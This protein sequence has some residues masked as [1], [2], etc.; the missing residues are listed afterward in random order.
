MEVNGDRGNHLPG[1]GRRERAGGRCGMDRG[2]LGARDWRAPMEYLG[3]QACLDG[4]QDEREGRDTRG[5][6]IEPKKQKNCQKDKG[7]V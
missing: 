3:T 6:V 1:T 5:K 7:R 4:G 2:F